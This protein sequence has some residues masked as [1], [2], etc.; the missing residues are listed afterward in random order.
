MIRR[1]SFVPST[2]QKTTR[3]TKL[4]PFSLALPL[5]LA[6][7]SCQIIFGFPFHT[8]GVQGEITVS[9]KAKQ[10]PR[11][12][13]NDTTTTT[14]TTTTIT[15]LLYSKNHLG[16]KRGRHSGQTSSRHVPKRLMARSGS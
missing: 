3:H 12:R 13:R 11:V 4:S 15:S 5:L 14:T 9:T 2:H 8:L 10:I 6:Q 16:K 7:N 1:V